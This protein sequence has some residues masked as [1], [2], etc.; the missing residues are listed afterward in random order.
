LA[1]DKGEGRKGRVISLKLFIS[2]LVVV[3]VVL[4]MLG[5]YVYSLVGANSKLGV[6]VASL[7]S[8]YSLLSTRYES[9]LNNYSSL[10][11]EYTALNNRYNALITNYTLLSARYSLLEANYNTINNQYNTLKSNYNDLKTQ[12]DTLFN[13]YTMLKSSYELLKNQY[14]QLL[15]DYEALKAKYN[16]SISMT[17]PVIKIKY[18]P[19]KVVNDKIYDLRIEIEAEDNNTPIAY[20]KLLFIPVRYDYF[21]TKY[22]M[23]PE[24]YSKA[25]PNVNDGRTYILRPLDG[26]FDEL[27][28]EFVIDITNITGGGEYR[29]ITVVGNSAGI[30]G[31]NEIKTPYIRQFEN[32]G[33]QLYEKEII[34]GAS[35]MSSYQPFIF[36][37]KMDDYPLLGKYT[38]PPIARTDEIVL[39]KHVDW[40]TGH[41]INV[42]FIDAGAWE[43]WKIDGDE[44]A[45]MRSLMDKSIKCAF[46][47]YA[48]TKDDRYFVKH[49]EP[50]APEWTIDLTY[51]KN[52][53][54]F[55]SQLSTILNSDLI[56]HPNYFRINGKP[57]IFIYDATV[58]IKESDAWTDLLNSV[59]SFY[60]IGDIIHSVEDPYEVDKWLYTPW[61]DLSKYNAI[62][63]WVGFIGNKWN[64][65]NIVDN[66]NCWFFLMNKLWS[67][68]A[69]EKNLEYVAS[70]SPGFKY[71]YEEKGLP[72]SVEG[73]KEMIK[74]F[75]SLYKI[76][77][78]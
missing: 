17:K 26:S 39:W 59:G 21:I 58:F 65:P 19:T 16:A 2:V 55:L 10:K 69:K 63:S 5:F 40:A 36:G 72:R 49:T 66:P 20:A 14:E 34:V 53:E 31:M 62:S 46:L 57:V 54:S 11:A 44:G 73:F 64:D 32:F 71:Y 8:N 51:P 76:Y 56:R 48:W 27:K 33:K 67:K 43:K 60:L 3:T 28:E 4:S 70:I 41:G 35:Y 42:F 47:W 38:M 61:K 30:E 6:R 29:I 23:K 77:K 13:N 25:F 18:T 24:D 12:Y 37:E 68:F 9:L 50:N 52:R 7:S 15:N 1:S 45:I 75:S 78:N 22:G 74:K